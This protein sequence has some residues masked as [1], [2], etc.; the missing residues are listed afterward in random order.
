MMR[1]HPT[2]ISG[3]KWK[4]KTYISEMCIILKTYFWSFDLVQALT[5]YFKL[6]F[7]IVQ[8]FIH[9]VCRHINIIYKMRIKKW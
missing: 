8:K 9:H 5:T 1:N 6:K 4:R 7:Y 2:V 3:Y